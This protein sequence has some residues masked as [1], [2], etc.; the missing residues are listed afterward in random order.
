MYGLY[1]TIYHVYFKMSIKIFRMRE[2]LELIRLNALG[3]TV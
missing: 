3:V 1:T 2:Q